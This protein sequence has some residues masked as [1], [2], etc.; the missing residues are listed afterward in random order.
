MV[1]KKIVD[2]KKLA[3]KVGSFSAYMH[4]GVYQGQIFYGVQARMPKTIEEYEREEGKPVSILVT[5]R[6]AMGLNDHQKEKTFFAYLVGVPDFFPNDLV[7][8]SETQVA[9]KVK[10]EY[11]GNQSPILEKKTLERILKRKE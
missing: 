5:K 3:Y 4:T 7:V 11:R 9:K 10:F 2:K 6:A 8:D 1:D